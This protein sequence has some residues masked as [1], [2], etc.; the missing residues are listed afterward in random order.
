MRTLKDIHAYM[1]RY[2]R[3]YLHKY[4]HTYGLTYIYTVHQTHMCTECSCDEVTHYNNVIKLQFSFIIHYGD[5]L[6]YKK[7]INLITKW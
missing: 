2:I 5:L 1:R 6:N 4:V 7:K 3:T